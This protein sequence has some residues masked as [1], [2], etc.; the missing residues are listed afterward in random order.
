VDSEH[1]YGAITEQT[2]TASHIVN[3]RITYSMNDGALTTWLSQFWPKTPGAPGG[4]AAR[5]A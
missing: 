1:R 5:M 2:R 3:P 4:T